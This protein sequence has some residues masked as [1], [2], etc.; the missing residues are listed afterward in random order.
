MSPLLSALRDAV[1][2][3]SGLEDFEILESIGAGFFAE[4]FKVRHVPTDQIMVLKMNKNATNSL[5]SL[6]E[7][8]LLKMLHHPHTLQYVG[9]CVSGGQLHPLTE[10][11]NG[12]SL[13][14]LLQDGKVDLSWSVRVKLAKEIAFGMQYLH[15]HGFLHRDLNSRNCL[16]REKNGKYTSVVADFGLATNLERRLFPKN[17]KSAPRKLMSCV[18][19]AYWMAPEVLN[20]KPYD[21]KADIFSY[22]I[23]LCEII[24]RKSADP[25]DIPR[26][27]DFQLD[28]QGFSDMIKDDGCPS[29]FLELT[30]KCCKLLPIERPSFQEVIKQFEEIEMSMKS[31][32]KSVLNSAP[33]VSVSTVE[34]DTSGPINA[35]TPKKQRAVRSQSIETVV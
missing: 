1:S 7:V 15:S 16:L 3:V 13:E 24:S 11:V 22:G 2:T 31:Q 18:G 5:K 23:V 20:H 12:G 32:A 6:R 4:V 33:K 10:Y 27:R 19:T 21:E 30:F 26:L 9:A 25:D 34:E 14:Q 35:W 17:K 8:E 29:G 28:E